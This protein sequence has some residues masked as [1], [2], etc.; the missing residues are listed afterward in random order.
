L[1]GNNY[2]GQ[3][4]Q[5]MF[6]DELRSSV[7]ENVRQRE[8]RAFRSV[9]PPGAMAE[10]AQR[11]GVK[12]GEG[13]LN[14]GTLAWLSL[15]AA[16]RPGLNFCRILHTTLRLLADMNALPVAP[17]A[18]RRRGPRRSRRTTRRKRHDPRSDD[19]T[20][21][22]EEA[23]AQARRLLP[24]R[25]WG[26]LIGLLGELFESRP[27]HDKLV[28]WNGFRLLALDGSCI[29]LPRWRALGERYG[30]A[31]NQHRNAVPQ[32]RIVMLQ[33][34]LVR[35][36]WRYELTE[37]GVGESTVANRLLQDIRPNDLVLM[38]RGFFHFDLFRQ[39]ADAGA[40]FA[41]R[42]IKRLRT[43]TIRRLGPDD[44]LMLWTPAARRWQGATMR[45]RVLRYQIRGYRASAVVTNVLD[46]KRLSRRQ[47]VGLADSSAWRTER[48]AGLYHRRWEIETTFRELKR[49]QQMQGGLR[50]RT[51]ETIEFEVAGHVILY[52]LVRWLMVEAAAKQGIDE[53]L[54]ISFAEA[55]VEV[56][57]ASRVLP[58]P[59]RWKRLC[60]TLAERMLIRIAS[61]EVPFRPGRHYPR[62][63]DA[64]PRCTGAGH[65][66]LSAK[67]VA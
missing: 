61:H 12:L 39:I 10:A 64:K 8:L 29:T 4:D 43:R 42:R 16:L 44:R 32:A 46:P 48:D 15:A 63:N 31:R 56:R 65:R 14:V 67:L 41:I 25:Y 58:L 45:L 55:L 49:V 47:I 37:R 60:R 20:R 2:F 9:L 18:P 33:L 24:H 62:P 30:Y 52:L 21:L 53:P 50:G 6:T 34:P 11:A 35:L 17:P 1:F 59:N 40:Y 36:P 22:S 3:E 57:Y 7:W 26:A 66:L 54:R 51:P 28:N 38:D 23:F 19:P 27:G 5:T 13:V